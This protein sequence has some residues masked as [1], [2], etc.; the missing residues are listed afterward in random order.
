MIN[1]KYYIKTKKKKSYLFCEFFV[2][3]FVIFSLSISVFPCL[4]IKKL[5]VSLSV[6]KMYPPNPTPKNFSHTKTC[7]EIFD[8]GEFLS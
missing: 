7:K 1:V 5:N 2:F 3:F 4:N 8:S 6:N